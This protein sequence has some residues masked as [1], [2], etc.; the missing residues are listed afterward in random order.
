MLDVQEVLEEHAEIN[1]EISRPL[2]DQDDLEELDA[3]LEA[4][5]LEDAA[6]EREK[7]QKETL[8]RQQ[9]ED[10]TIK[11]LAGLKVV[12]GKIKMI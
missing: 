8:R 3:E 9:E 11:R 7:E 10:D 12:G 5:L 6:A 2:D 1:A 4:M